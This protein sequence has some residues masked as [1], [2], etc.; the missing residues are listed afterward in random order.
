MHVSSVPPLCFYPYDNFDK[1]RGKIKFFNHD[2]Y[3]TS[4][5]LKLSQLVIHCKCI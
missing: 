5:L 4:Q 1:S 3:F 2:R